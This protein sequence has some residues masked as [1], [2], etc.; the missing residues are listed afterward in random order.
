MAITPKREEEDLR[1]LAAILLLS[2]SYLISPHCNF[3]FYHFNELALLYHTAVS[4]K[5]SN[6]IFA[7]CLNIW[8]WLS[9]VFINIE[10]IKSIN[11]ILII[12]SLLQKGSAKCVRTHLSHSFPVEAWVPV[13]LVVQHVKVLADVWY[14]AD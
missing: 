13:R 3:M 10:Q 7:I 9:G 12:K 4:H 1:L 11:K 2:G 14:L 5:S 6:S 8:K